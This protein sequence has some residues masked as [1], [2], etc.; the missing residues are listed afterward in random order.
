MGG[1]LKMKS[2]NKQRVHE[3][4]ERRDGSLWI[5]LGTQESLAKLVAQCGGDG[6]S[7]NEGGGKGGSESESGSDA[8]DAEAAKK[9]A[10]KAAFQRKKQGRFDSDHYAFM[11][12][13]SIKDKSGSG[14]GGGG[15]SRRRMGSG[16]RRM[17]GQRSGQVLRAGGGGRVPLESYGIFGKNHQK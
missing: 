12:P 15:G 7:K 5:A 8:A 13:T 1:N 6:E 3:V 4:T 2:G 17:R 14:G 9:A 10:R 16:G 11:E